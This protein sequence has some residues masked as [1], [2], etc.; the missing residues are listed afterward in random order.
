MFCYASR[1]RHS[2]YELNRFEATRSP[3]L[4][5]F[6]MNQQADVHSRRSPFVARL[7]PCG[8]ESKDLFPPLF[9]AVVL[10]AS[11]A[12]W[13]VRGS[14]REHAPNGL[15]AYEQTWLLRELRACQIDQI[16]RM[17]AAG[18]VPAFIP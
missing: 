1:L 6:H 11:G 9:D 4:G 10:Y 8:G 5:Q 3:V 13:T 2:G 7:L 16:E 14:E 15:V 18:Q 17:L 12:T